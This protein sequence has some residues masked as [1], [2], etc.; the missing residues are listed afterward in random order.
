MIKIPEKF[1][2]PQKIIN[3]IISAAKENKIEKIFLF[4]SRARGDFNEKSDIDIAISG[5]NAAEFCL[6]INED[7]STLLKFDI[8]RLTK[9][10]Y[11]SMFGKLKDAVETRWLPKAEL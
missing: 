1:G 8:V 4:G 3:E 10:K 11:I 2:L 7:V 5:G 9:E 6:M